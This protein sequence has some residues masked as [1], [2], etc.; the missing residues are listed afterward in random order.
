MDYE[1]RQEPKRPEVGKE[2][3]DESGH[4]VCVWAVCQSHVVYRHQPFNELD[5]DSRQKFSTQYL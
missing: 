3:S 1:L 4:K 2:Y 5:V